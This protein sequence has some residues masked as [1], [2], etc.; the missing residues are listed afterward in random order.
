MGEGAGQAR[1]GQG[2]AHSLAQAEYERRGPCGRGQRRFT[3]IEFGVKEAA[4][5]GLFLGRDAFQRA[6]VGEGER[7]G[8]P[9][10][11]ASEAE[12]SGRVGGGQGRTGADHAARGVFGAG[13]K[14]DVEPAAKDLGF[15]AVGGLE[16]GLRGFERADVE[17]AVDA[18][19]KKRAV[20]RCGR[21]G[22][23]QKQG[24]KKVAHGR[25]AVASFGADE[26]DECRGIAACPERGGQARHVWREE[27]SAVG[28]WAV[29][30]GDGDVGGGGILGHRGFVEDA[31]RSAAGGEGCGGDALAQPVD[32][33]EGGILLR[34]GRK[35]EEEEREERRASHGG[36]S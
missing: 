34:D 36:P 25:Q 9:V 8:L 30:R 28:R 5:Q 10:A 3:L 7:G 4:E 35:G 1:G 23:G 2:F 27:A 21:V 20:G 11:V 17:Q 31:G 26:R 24:H 6:G 13:E 22:L 32:G 14:R 15:F 18:G 16:E 29:E 33:G 12:D 19:E